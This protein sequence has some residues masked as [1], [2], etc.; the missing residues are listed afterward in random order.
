MKGG[1]SSSNRGQQSTTKTG[2]Q[3][4]QG[5]Y[6]PTAEQVQY[7]QLLNHD[8]PE[9]LTAK[10]QKIVEMTQKPQ[11]E[12]AIALH[13]CDNNIDSAVLNLLEGKYNQGEWTTFQ[14]RKKKSQ[15]ADT[16]SP[17][18]PKDKTGNSRPDRK[19]NRER[20]G[21]SSQSVEYNNRR[22]KGQ[23]DRISDSAPRQNG[24]LNN[25][26]PPGGGRNRNREDRDDQQGDQG[27]QQEDR[28]GGRE[29]RRGDRDS[30]QSGDRT[31]QSDRRSNYRDRDRNDRSNRGG[32]GGREDRWDQNDRGGGDRGDRGGER[33]DRGGVN[34]GDRDMDRGDRGDRGGDRWN[35]GDRGGD[36]GEKRFGGRGGFNKRGGG[37]G[38]GGRGAR[39]S[40]GGRFPNNRSGGRRF[41]Q[42]PN[43]PSKDSSEFPSTSE[44]WDAQTPGKD[45]KDWGSSEAAGITEDWGADDWGNEKQNDTS[46]MPSWATTEN[47]KKT[48]TWE[49][50]DN[51]ADQNLTNHVNHLPECDDE[52]ILSS[53]IA[54]K[55]SPL[56]QNHEEPPR[57]STAPTASSQPYPSDAPK[58][59][60]LPTDAPSTTPKDTGIASLANAGLTK[61]TNHRPPSM[62]R[63]HASAGQVTASQQPA[64]N[65]AADSEPPQPQRQQKSRTKRLPKGQIPKQAVEMPGN[66]GGVDSLDVQFGNLEF[67]G[68]M[69]TKGKPEEARIRQPKEESIPLPQSGNMNIPQQAS[70]AAVVST[71]PSNITKPV[72]MA[73]TSM[74][75]ESSVVDTYEQMSPRHY[76][77]PGTPSSKSAMTQITPEPSPRKVKAE[78]PREPKTPP[79]S[80]TALA[81]KVDVSTSPMP[82]TTTM[83]ASLAKNNEGVASRATSLHSQIEAL[84]TSD[85]RL[86]ERVHQQAPAIGH[87]P[88]PHADQSAMRS[89]L[90]VT[91]SSTT[92]PNPTPAG[93]SLSASGPA[94]PPPGIISGIQ[95]AATGPPKTSSTNVINRPAAHG[96][97]PP[98][99]PPGVM[100]LYGMQPA[101]G[102]A[103]FSPLAYP[104]DDVQMLQ[105]M[106]MPPYGYDIPFP[107]TGR[108]G[109][110][111]AYSGADVKYNRND[112]SSPV[113][114]TLTAGPH[115]QQAT[116]FINTHAQL[117]PFGFA[118]NLAFYHGGGMI[119]GM[120]YTAQMYQLPAKGPGVTTQF[121][122]TFANQ[123]GPHYTSGYDGLSS[124]HDFGKQGYQHPAQSKA[125]PV[126]G[127]TPSNSASDLST[128]YKP[129][130][131]D[132]GYLSGTPP[133]LNISLPGQGHQPHPAGFPIMPVL[134]PTQ[135]P[136]SLFPSHHLS[137]QQQLDN[138]NQN[139]GAQNQGKVSQNKS[140]HAPS[141]Y[142]PHQPFWSGT[143]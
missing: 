83:T 7:A 16:I 88:S 85:E 10:I 61:M 66:N 28:R 60:G 125:N 37:M 33:S 67:D 137:H 121:Q 89:R 9:W 81:K 43:G 117:H 22:N 8:D 72:P 53:K 5:K 105:R 40:R 3:S 86:D 75:S 77:T 76:A 52:A 100:P 107:V 17:V 39:G 141:I 84:T 130:F 110:Q 6:Q 99:L 116:P 120:P 103:G 19:D 57:F 111:N 142:P 23:T 123:L 124:T 44:S 62:D 2:K 82:L 109:V 54:S 92:R 29:G 38:R 35:S 24:P 143:N 133:P 118:S 138:L 30:R 4:P 69:M 94:G 55:A 122:Q 11:D 59:F 47:D 46:N 79:M 13:D 136:P 106:Q 139:R 58:S 34:R 25:T 95:P 31:D 135:H 134:A 132:K 74:T 97:K 1:T 96:T 80:T 113:P 42:L 70:P 18:N 45:E 73:T 12:V 41:E 14:P 104:L 131:A 65:M 21:G 63:V 78:P 32:R 20:G 90:G 71:V 51:H 56:L 112:T 101:P 126:S 15:P 68:E 26:R 140:H 119:H 128:A 36:R 27:D 127:S 49:T 108:D 98:N 115:G 114:S 64:V 102:F 91:S 48:N 129:Q 93:V 87:S 50:R